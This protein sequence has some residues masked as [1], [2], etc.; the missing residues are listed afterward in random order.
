[1]S[2]VRR[3]HRVVLGRALGEVMGSYPIILG[4]SPELYLGLIVLTMWKGFED[5]LNAL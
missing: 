2:S 3:L 5:E 1:M 4:S